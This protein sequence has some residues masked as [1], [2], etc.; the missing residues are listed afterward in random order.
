MIVLVADDYAISAGVSCGIRSLAERRRISATSA[1][2]TRSRWQRDAEALKLLRDRIAIGLHLNL[3]FGAPLGPMRHLSPR[4]T[5]PSISELTRVTML[6]VGNRNELRHE[7]EAEIS[8]QLSAFETAT[9]FA[10]DSIDGHQHAHVLPLVRDALLSV[11]SARFPEGAARPL[12]RVPADRAGAILARRAS[13]LKASAI[14]GLAQGF[15]AA[16][17]SAGF[18]VNDSFAGVSS[19]VASADAVTHDL[20][21]AAQH[22]GPLHIVMCHPGVASG[23]LNGA[24]EIAARRIA[25][26][27]VLGA[28]NILT[29]HL[30][31]PR[32]DADGPVI[33]WSHLADEPE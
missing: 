30:W 25:E 5:L 32:R 4:G 2:V 20:H 26:L 24:D 16:A 14:A 13:T 18:P 1:I 7:I 10:P 3:T 23:D 8:R 15:S 22:R 9:G 19:F 6:S 31:R 29:P 17:R 33:D 28:D 12:I 27:A 11:L 21:Q